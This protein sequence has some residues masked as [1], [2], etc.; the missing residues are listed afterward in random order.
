M[1]TTQSIASVVRSDFKAFV[2]YAF[3]KTDDEEL[4]DQPYVD[5]MC[6]EIE[7]LISGKTKRLLIN[8]PPQH[9]KSFVGTICLAAYLLGIKPR[10]RLI[11]T[12]YNETFAESLGFKIRDMMQTNWY[13]NVF[14]TRIKEG[15]ARANDF[16]TVKGGG[17]FAAARPDRSPAAPRISSSTTIRT[18]SATGTT[19]ASSRWCAT[20]STPLSPDCMTRR[21]A[22]CL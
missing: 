19:S 13:K 10:L 11:V 3:R 16:A 4:G 7:K 2:R 1:A 6:F 21:P 9:L 8:L 14:D 12:A 17:V 20:I 22:R 5:H 15:H 18:K